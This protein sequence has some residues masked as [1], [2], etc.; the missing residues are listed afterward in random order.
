MSPFELLGWLAT[1]GAIA[2]VVLNNLKNKLCFLVWLFTNAISCG[3]H[4]R[5]WVGGDGAMLT[6]AVRDAVFL[7]LAVHGWVI[8]GRASD[9][10]KRKKAK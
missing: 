1:C 10:A 8:W 3:L 4:V 6:L 2:G 5:G 9:E 7:M